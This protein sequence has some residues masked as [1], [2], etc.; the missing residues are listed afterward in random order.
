VKNLFNILNISINTVKEGYGFLILQCVEKNVT[1]IS[2]Y[3]ND[4]Q[5]NFLGQ[6][7]ILLPNIRQKL[8]SNTKKININIVLLD[9]TSRSHFYRSL[10]KTLQMIER[11]NS[12]P[13]NAADILDFELFQAINGH[14]NTNIRALFTGKLYPKNATN[15]ERE[16]L[17]FDHFFGKFVA[18]GYK[19]YYQDD[20]CY[21]NVWGLRLNLGTPGTWKKFKRSLRDN[22]IHST[23]KFD[24]IPLTNSFSAFRDRRRPLV[25]GGA[26]SFHFHNDTLFHDASLKRNSPPP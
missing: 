7:L 25:Y 16:L 15:D 18:N 14:T 17:G 20:M 5:K 11:I 10:P 21:D 26:S 6:L 4:D 2:D 1:S 23:G 24:T 3:K 8:E 19:T 22:H 9:S 13:T 12:D